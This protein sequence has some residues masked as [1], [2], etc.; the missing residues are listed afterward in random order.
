[1]VVDRIIFNRKDR[2]RIIDSLELAFRFG[3]GQL[4][5]WRMDDV[6]MAFSEALECPRCHI[7]YAG[8]T[9]N[10]FSFNSP[11]GACELC[12]GFGRTIDI[13][14]DLIIPDHTL[15]LEEGA[16]K[17]WG[18]WEEKKPEYED[19]VNFCRKNLIPIDVEFGQLNK[20]QQ[21]SIIEGTPDYYGIR[22]FFRWLETK[23]YKMPVRVYL[24][25]Y[26]SYDI[27]RECL[28]TRFKKE[29]LL[30]RLKGKTIA[31]IYAQSVHWAFDFFDHIFIPHEDKAG[32]MVLD[33]VQ[34]RLKYL[35]D[36]GLG[37]LTLDRQ[38]RT[39]SGGEVQ[40]VSLAAA[41]GSSLVNTLYILDEPSIGLHP[42]DTHRL[43]SILHNLRDL[44]NTL[45]VV[46]H[47]PDIISQS[48]Y[49]LD[50]GPGAGENGGEVMYFGPTS[51]VDSSLTG[52][53]LKGEK[54]L[55]IP[56][57]RKI[58]QKNKWLSI[59]GAS[60]NNLKNIDISIPF[61]TIRLPDRC[62]RFRKIDP[63]PRNPL[64][65]NQIS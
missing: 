26:R 43:V 13:D 21:W 30:Y 22:G 34:S 47:D 25:R 20:E 44:S 45:V 58:P 48:D 42:S 32:L 41:L 23:T 8:P 27:C 53:Y 2:K 35:K 5:I 64:Q 49:L 12:R 59:R 54:F 9:P 17:P 16:I 24:S 46:E 38:S 31:E 15:T 55:P 51:H 14:M 60:E 7:A 40:R 19:L 61:R 6:H 37:Y 4:D 1:V 57:Y 65:G 56:E 33:A 39:L 3:G 36:V 62:I 29:T 11:A 52:Q 18:T 10:L 63:G 28:G 50:L